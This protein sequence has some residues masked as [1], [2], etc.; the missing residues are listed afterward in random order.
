MLKKIN[1]KDHFIELIK[2][3]GEMMWFHGT[4]TSSLKKIL[5]SKKMKPFLADDSAYGEAI[6][7]SND[8]ETAEEYG[9]KGR[10]L[11]IKNSTLK[12]YKHKVITAYMD[13]R[14]QMNISRNDDIKMG[15]D[16]V[17]FDEIP[18]KD[19]FL[20]QSKNKFLPLIKIK[21]SQS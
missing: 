18:I 14:K 12:K 3:E 15:A 6:W 7:F 10:I 5:A 19:I 2:F 13:L 20:V 4:S 17:V 1:P 21:I 11:A 9:K 16:L 8:W